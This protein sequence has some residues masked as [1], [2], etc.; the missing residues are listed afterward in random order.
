MTELV[1]YSKIDDVAVL[2][3]NNPPVNA[4]SPGVPEGITAGVEAA[5]NDASVAAVVLIGGGR[6]FIAGADINEF[7]KLTSGE[8]SREEGSLHT[9]L[10]LLEDTPKPIVCAIHGTA[11]GGGLEV[12]M[13]C[14]YRVASP[15]ASVGQPEVKL[16]I[17]PGAAGTQ[18][19]PRLCGIAKAAEMCA[20]GNPV[21][22]S[23]AC[24]LGIVDRLVEGDLLAGACAFARERIESGE[25]PRRTR[26]IQDR[27]GDSEKNAESLE[28][29]R[30]L[31]TSKARG[32][33]AG[34]RAIDAVELA[35]TVSFENACEEEA[36]L[37]DECL[38][39]PQS[40]GLIHVFF[41]E[42]A[43]A[44][45]P[46]VPKDT[47]RLSIESAAVIG[48]GT[49]GAGIAMAY[50]NAGIPVVLKEADQERLDRGLEVI[51]GQYESAVKK[52]RMTPEQF[53]N[54]MELIQPTLAYTDIGAANIVVEAV[55]EDMSLKKK[56]FA[57]I[58]DAAREGAILASNTSTLDID[59]IASVTRR[60]ES[61][62]GHH[63]FSP[64][65]LMRL[66]EIV[67]GKATSLDV[68]AT[69]MALSK[70]LRK[71]GVLVGNGWG[72]VGNRMFG[73]FMREAQV[74]VE[75][76]A[77][78]EAVDAAM[79]EFGMAM[80]PLAVA[81]LAGIDVGWRVRQESADRVPPGLREPIVPDRLY[82]LGRYGQ[83]T[84]AGWYRYEE[85]AR[86]PTLDPEVVS[87]VEDV[88]RERG[89]PQRQIGAEE[90]VERIVYGL[91]NEGAHVLGEGLA[92]R[93]SDI[94]IVYING[95]GFPAY[96]GGPMFYADTVG[97]RKVHARLCEFEER[98]G[99]WWKPA[100]LLEEL[101]H[102]GKGFADYPLT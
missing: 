12:A 10:Q 65:H 43:V 73:P 35:A 102:Q 96:R 24:Y 93:S 62:I 95:Y 60:P 51:R 30:K 90:I 86:R 50:V 66:L 100:P 45:I 4:L 15:T 37:F 84:G 83:K 58:D 27:F 36:K 97:L 99:F 47:P 32:Q 72:F 42:R 20:M 85:G 67:R 64:A 98:F 49:M 40:K 18:R 59:E 31:V 76:G 19:L 2:T 71:I 69:S 8:K 21:L 88:V 25:P 55:F 16:G 28:Q 89:I 23:E 94:D 68:I 52:R 63:F 39:S 54:H 29:L 38:Y 48:A 80:G 70:K 46:D 6:T 33:I 53:E 56:V 78:I 91:I 3:V 74:L 75:E 101:A 17:I 26:E 92:L 87:L 44:K 1:S 77:G 79:T 34:L 61:V 22:A 13:A 57:E 81:D 9:L 14:H 11:L 5:R 41:S 7:G 82:R